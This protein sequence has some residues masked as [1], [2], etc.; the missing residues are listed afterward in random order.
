MILNIDTTNPDKEQQ[1]QELLPHP[2]RVQ[3]AVLS[4]QLEFKYQS[5]INTENKEYSVPLD[6]ILMDTTREIS[7][8]KK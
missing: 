1:I 5:K 4:P 7:K 2:M 3:L 8:L 6:N